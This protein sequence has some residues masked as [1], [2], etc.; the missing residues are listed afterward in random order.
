MAEILCDREEVNAANKSVNAANKSVNAA[1]KSVIVVCKP[2]LPHPVHSQS[3]STFVVSWALSL[4]T[5]LLEAGVPDA[6]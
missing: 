5:I 4:S 3:T 2:V 1:N 6:T